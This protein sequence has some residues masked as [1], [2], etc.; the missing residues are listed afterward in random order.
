MTRRK[1]GKSYQCSIDI[2]LTVKRY[3]AARPYGRGFTILGYVDAPDVAEAERE[4]RRKWDAGI[5]PWKAATPAQRL[6]AVRRQK[7]ADALV[8]PRMEDYE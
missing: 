2:R 5:M 1:V 4:A 6:V 8:A 7:E 3:I